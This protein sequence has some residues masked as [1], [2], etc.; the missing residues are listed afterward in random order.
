[1]SSLPDG[2][3]K[4]LRVREARVLWLSVAVALVIAA[5]GFF[6]PDKITVVAVLATIGNLIG[7]LWLSPP[8]RDRGTQPEEPPSWR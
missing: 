1:M 8:P 6:A 4:K 5:T 3:V 2:S 7:L